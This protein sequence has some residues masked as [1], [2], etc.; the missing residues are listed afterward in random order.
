VHLTRH[1]EIAI[2][3]LVTC[4]RRPHECVH[5]SVAAAEASATKAHAAKVAHL[6]V[7]AGF[8]KTSRGRQG[9]LRLARPAE[10]ISL[11]SVLQHTQPERVGMSDRVQRRKPLEARLDMIMGSARSAVAA[12][13]ERFTVADLIARPVGC[14]DCGLFR[15]YRGALPV[16]PPHAFQQSEGS[17]VPH[18]G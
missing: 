14:V 16:V 4:A 18:I 8:L 13:M 5:T 15:A 1:S 7:H 9:G 10:R 12:L 2:A 3:I 11:A 6:L 17:H